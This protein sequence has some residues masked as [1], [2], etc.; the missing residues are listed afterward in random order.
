MKKKPGLLSAIPSDE[1]RWNTIWKRENHRI[2]ASL[3]LTAFPDRARDP[4]AEHED[5][6]TEDIR[7]PGQFESSS[8]EEEED[9]SFSGRESLSADL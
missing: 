2:L 8:G 1:K 4:Q 5:L 9:L 3:I 6:Q 7:N